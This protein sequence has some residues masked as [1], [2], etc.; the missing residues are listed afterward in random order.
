MATSERPIPA[1]A[2]A[3]GTLRGVEVKR[4]H[5]RL[6]GMVARREVAVAE[7]I[8]A[9]SDPDV[10]GMR[11]KT[12]LAAAPGWTPEGVASW[13]AEAGIPLDKRLRGL[14]P[15]QREAVDRRFGAV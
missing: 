14:G 3:R 7:V 6:R 1:E 15:L 5:A 11:L 13:M 10:G 2:R 9:A 8:D 4:I 12:L